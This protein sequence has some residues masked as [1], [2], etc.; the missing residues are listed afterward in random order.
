MTNNFDIGKFNS[1]IQ[2]A[3]QQISC[4]SE[5]QKEKKAKEL[6]DKY[7]NAEAN[8]S[9]AEPQYQISKKE[10][11]S[12]VNGQ[13]SYNQ[14]LEEEE[15]S[16]ADKITEKINDKIN[17]TINNIN[18][19]LQ[20]YDGLL[21]NFRNVLDLFR[22]YKKENRFLEQKLKDESNDVLINNRKTYYEDQNISS[23]NSIYYYILLIIYIIVVICF[24]VFSLIY[25]STISLK[26]KLLLLVVFIALPFI[27]TFILGKIIE[28][29][30]WIFNLLPKNV[31]L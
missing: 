15:S 25:P 31:Y 2:A 3:S 13:D 12:Y 5:C 6:K 11:Y 30:Y 4:G 29:I 23:L 19:L 14:M 18:S 22:Q 27:S 20:T 8:L 9:L 26:L 7:L 17:T 16:R 24:I 28:F 10:Y 21:I 1:F